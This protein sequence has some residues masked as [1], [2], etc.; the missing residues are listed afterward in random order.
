MAKLPILVTL[1]ILATAPLI[2][3]ARFSERGSLGQVASC[4]E[5]HSQGVSHGDH[6]PTYPH[7]GGR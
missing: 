5:R 6:P 2:L 7:A 3:A 4:A 1:L